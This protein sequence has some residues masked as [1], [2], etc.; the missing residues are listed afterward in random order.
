MERTSLL[1]PGNNTHS[2]KRFI[3]STVEKGHTR[4]QGAAPV[5]VVKNYN[6]NYMK[7]MIICLEI[8]GK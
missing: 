5:D 3:G 7:P 8:N 4:K 6:N 2:S 1:Y